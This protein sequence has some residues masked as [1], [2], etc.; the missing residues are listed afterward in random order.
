[1]DGM[2]GGKVGSVSKLRTGVP[3]PGRGKDRLMLPRRLKPL[4]WDADFAALD[5][6]RHRDYIIE[7]IL[8][9]GDVPEI[10][11][12]QATYP[13]ADIVRVLKRARGLSPRSATYWSLIYDVPAEE[14]ACLNKPYGLI[15]WPG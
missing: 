12:M 8:E 13:V 7:R 10:S 3:Q 14:I 15:P 9:Y 5:A 2:A 11:W 4:F 1:M 6:V